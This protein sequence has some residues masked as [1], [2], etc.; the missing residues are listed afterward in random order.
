VWTEQLGSAPLHQAS[1]PAMSHL[2]A[3]ALTQVA[4][5]KHKLQ[6]ALRDLRERMTR[7]AHDAGDV[8]SRAQ[9][10]AAVARARELQRGRLAASL[11]K[12]NRS[13]VARQ[14]D[15]QIAALVE[16]NLDAQTTPEVGRGTTG[17]GWRRRSSR[18]RVQSGLACGGRAAQPLAERPFWLERWRCRLG[19]R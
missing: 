10:V 18:R 15:E 5:A 6:E 17:R 19:V 3:L 8:C 7:T 2:I 11:A 13:K 9:G 16:K 12:Q 4:Y 1:P 14:S